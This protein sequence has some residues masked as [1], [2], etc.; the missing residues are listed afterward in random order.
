MRKKIFAGIIFAMLLTGCSSSNNFDV[1]EDVVYL[2]TPTEILFKSSDDNTKT[3]SE[4]K[5]LEF[6]NTY[7]KSL[8]FERFKNSFIG[9]TEIEYSYHF[10]QYQNG[11]KPI[12]LFLANF[13]MISFRLVRD[14]ITHEFLCN[15]EVPYIEMHEFLIENSN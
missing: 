6:Y 3:L 15:E 12:Q 11:D 13:N 14:N 9:G 2:P 10:D 1:F 8:K 7:L 4:E 5:S